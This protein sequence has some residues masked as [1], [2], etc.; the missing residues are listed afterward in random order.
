MRSIHRLLYLVV[1]AFALSASIQPAQ[2]QTLFKAALTP[3]QETSD[4]T[5]DASGTAAVVLKNDEVEFAISVDGL[6]GPMTGAHFHRGPL[7][8]NGSV[9]RA[10]TA[11]FTGNSASGVWRETD[12][13]P[14]TRDLID[15]LFAGELYFN[16][17]TA[18]NPGGEIRGQIVPAVATMLTANLT[19]E[20]S[21]ADVTSDGS[22]TATFFMTEEEVV[23]DISVDGL[24]GPIASAHI[25]R[26][27]A[28]TNGSVVRSL[29]TEFDGNSAF[30]V[31]RF[32][33][34]EA[35][36]LELVE[37]LTTGGLY[38]N[39]HTAA[40]PGGEIRGQVE[41][42][43]GWGFRAVL[44]PGD[45]VT[46]D[47]RGSA[48][49]LLTTWGL[50]FS[51]TVEGLTGPI[52]VAH[53]HNAAAGTNGPPVRT[54]TGDFSGNTAGGLWSFDD[55]EPLT[56]EW[57]EELIAGRIYLN[58]HTAA[59]PGGEIRA[60][61][62][63]LDG[64][65]LRA[66]LTPEQE[67][68]DVT[69]DAAGTAVLHLTDAGLEFQVSVDGLSGPIVAAHFHNG[70][71]GTNGGPVRTITGDFT[72]N[73]ASGIWTATDGEPL[74]PDLVAELMKGNLYVNV[75]TAANGA[76]EIRGQV[77]IAGGTG[78]SARLTAAQESH[79][80]TSDAVGTASMLLT[81]Q[82]LAFAVTTQGLSGPATNAHFHSGSAG[83]NGGPVR[84]VFGDFSGST[85]EG[86]WSPEDGEP[87]TDELVTDLLLGRLYLNVHTGANPAG[88]IRGQ[89]FPT[90]EFGRVAQLDA[91]QE[92]HD[93]ISDAGGTATVT[94][95]PSGA[96]FD[97]TVE[98][99]SG[100]ITNAHFHNAPRGE[101]GGPVR[102][103]AGDFV[104]N[105]A[106][107]VWKATD[108][109]SFTIDR[110][111]ATANNEIYLNVHT[112]A[113][114]QGEIRGQLGEPA[115]E[116]GIER[117]GGLDEIPGQFVLKEN[118]PNPFNPSTTITFDL[119]ASGDVKLE[120]FDIL[121]RHLRTLI[122]GQMSAGQYRVDFDAADLPSGT[123]VTTLSSDGR[124][125]SRSMVLL[126]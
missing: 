112:A 19:P 81:P 37:A 96:V 4:V 20:Q 32:D 76:G 48:N 36:S 86:F 94:V 38:V 107:G 58:V 33:D 39:V 9:V 44:E 22:G 29:T 82:G 34:G 1:F 2:A 28:G 31:W 79:E 92:T 83:T 119:D 120:V 6:S 80:V 90:G 71:V 114:P 118:Y 15:A 97:L 102:T 121:G 41:L 105:T 95:S 51:S 75:H 125:Q 40:N 13:Q 124:R 45:G 21:T 35:L 85:A 73:T 50:V 3:A 17:H 77:F 72:G 66:A 42:K 98:G 87:L 60:Q 103:I 30:G 14:L 43:S 57:I 63:L 108:A 109:E 115:I 55:G 54:V 16:V 26:A 126:R 122:N 84:S 10:I 12:T 68:H 88:E 106:A 7:G 64:V 5:S 69:Q 93:V 61:L 100:P 117:I 104:G 24:T 67:T 56:G 70:A 65:P 27:P 49:A 62:E 53:F 59:N 25:H 52:T 74:T 110:V 47:A 101:N 89:V 113:N 99:L 123:Y 116:V 111:L 18:A 91:D 78:L 46:T 11:D 8:E 23:F